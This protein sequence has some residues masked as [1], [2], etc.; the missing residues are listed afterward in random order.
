MTSEMSRKAAAALPV[1]IR[2]L[3]VGEEPE[4]G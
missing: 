2:R 1:E 3:L 4:S